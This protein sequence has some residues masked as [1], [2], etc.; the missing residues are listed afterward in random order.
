MRTFY[1]YI[2]FFLSFPILGKLI[3]KVHLLCQVDSNFSIY[4]N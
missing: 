3:K 2:L 1:Y 4:K